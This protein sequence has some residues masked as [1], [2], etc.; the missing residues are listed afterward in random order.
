MHSKSNDTKFLTY[1]NANSV[2]DKLFESLLS[3][4]K[5]GLEASMKGSDFILDSLHLLYY[6]YQKTNFNYCGSYIESPDSIKNKKATINWKN[7]SDKCFQYA[8]TVTINYGENELH[9][10]FRILN[11]L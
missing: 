6:K 10:E 8:I 5:S 9:S 4:Y 1:G 2:V 7:K 3:R 11:W